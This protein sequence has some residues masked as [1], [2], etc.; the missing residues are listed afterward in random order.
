MKTK[1]IGLIIA[2]VWLL[3]VNVVREAIAQETVIFTDDFESQTLDNWSS[4]DPAWTNASASAHSGTRKARA[5]GPVENAFLTKMISTLGYEHIVL[6]FWYDTS[7][8]WGSN[9]TTIIEWTTNGTSWNVLGTLSEEDGTPLVL[10]GE[11]WIEKTFPLPAGADDISGFGIRFVATMNGQSERF[12]VDDVV[13]AGAHT[14]SGEPTPTPTPEPTPT[15]IPTPTPTQQPEPTPTVTP[16]PTQAPQPT[17]TPTPTQAPLPENGG[18]RG[19]IGWW[20]GLLLKQVLALLRLL[21]MR[22]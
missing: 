9:D 1:L 19:L 16:S 10:E 5:A 7:T 12:Y 18:S 21:F 2:T 8:S 3:N 13:L 11:E 22:W 6:R 14:G 17:A 4:V 15:H 20:L